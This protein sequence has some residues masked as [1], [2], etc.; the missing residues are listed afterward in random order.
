MELTLV[1]FDIDGTLVDSAA[2]ILDGFA[3]A[4]AAVG[5]PPAPSAQVLSMVGLSL[6]VVMAR[7]MPDADDA[8][9]EAAVGAHRDHFFSLRA[10]RGPASVPLFDGARAEIERLAAKPDVLIGAAT[11]MARRGLD[12]VLDTHGLGRHFVTR[13]TADGHPS[14]PHPAMLEAAVAETGVARE[15]T[16][17]VGDTTYD[18]EMA[19]SAGVTGIGVSWGHHARAALLNAG[20]QTV[21]T[22]FAALAQAIDAFREGRA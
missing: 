14:K 7:L 19:V 22:D 2:L 5:R 20:A 12:F 9:V 10:E 13:Q 21:V 18:I 3:H 17:M 16:V 15:S 8:T 11:G 6:P 4:L 1:V